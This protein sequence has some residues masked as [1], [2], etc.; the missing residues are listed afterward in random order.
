MAAQ[1][2]VA[3]RPVEQLALLALLTH[4]PDAEV[5]STAEA[6]L[7]RLPSPVVAAFLAKDDVPPE[8]R[9]F[10]AA[11]GVQPST[12]PPDEE[13]AALLQE[14]DTSNEEEE[15]AD[16]EG[17]HARRISE[18]SVPQRLKAAMKGTREMRSV[19]IRDTNRMV[20]LAV[21][22]SPKLTE[23][24]IESYARLGSVSE[25]VLRTIGQTRAWTKSYAVVTALIRNAR[26]P[27]AISLTLLQ[28]LNDRDVR[29]LSVDRNVPEPL[30]TAAR[31]KVVIAS[32]K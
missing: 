21:L 18:M 8:L 30:R 29:S 25:D 11:R 31:R 20:A 26:T 15:K 4:D 23:T 27:L 19:L 9:A 2:V 22:S 12:P 5:S 3:P 10:F 16:G 17:A 28:R 6:T 32:Q 13:A 7:E 1:G 14:S 24:E